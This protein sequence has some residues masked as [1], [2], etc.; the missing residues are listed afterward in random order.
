MN[1]RTDTCS[2]F[3]P[4]VVIPII[5]LVDICKLFPPP[6]PPP[7]SPVQIVVIHKGRVVEQGTHTELLARGGVYK[8]LVYRQLAAGDYS[9]DGLVDS[10]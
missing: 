1:F 8:Q 10:K 7:F 2:V 4:E 9:S 3:W 6:P 5:S